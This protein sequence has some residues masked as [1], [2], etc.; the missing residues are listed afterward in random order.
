MK[1]Y[2]IESTFKIYQMASYF[3]ELLIPQFT[4]LKP[5]WKRTGNKNIRKFEELFETNNETT[6]P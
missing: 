1:R 5:T 2:E 4:R 3:L 6:D